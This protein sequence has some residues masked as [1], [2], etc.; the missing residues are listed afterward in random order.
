[1]REGAA[2]TIEG[3]VYHGGGTIVQAQLGTVAIEGGTFSATAASS[4]RRR[5]ML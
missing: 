4:P 5:S 1:M 2:L 3:G